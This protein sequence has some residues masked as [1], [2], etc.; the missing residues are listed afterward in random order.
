MVTGNAVSKLKADPSHTPLAI[1][2]N[3]KTLLIQNAGDVK[4]FKEIAT[5]AELNTL[6]GSYI[7]SAFAVSPD[8]KQGLIATDAGIKRYDLSTGTELQT[9]NTDKFY[10]AIAITPDGSSFLTLDPGGNYTVWNLATG[11]KLHQLEG[12]AGWGDQAFAG[13]KIL[14]NAANH[15]GNRIT[16]WDLQTGKRIRKFCNE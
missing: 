5:G 1:S 9:F 12:K 6:K 16:L 15:T 14:V 3:N 8:R 2:A 7:E 11:A 10:R 13:A 4:R